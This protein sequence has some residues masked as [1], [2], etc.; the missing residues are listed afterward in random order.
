M[1]IIFSLKVLK[2]KTNSKVT[3]KIKLTKNNGLKLEVMTY[4]G[5][6]YAL[7]RARVTAAILSTKFVWTKQR[8][9]AFLLNDNAA[10]L[11]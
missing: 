2:K 3:A 7:R 4:Y 6:I 9:N 5:Y 1:K 10:K 8:A 11:E